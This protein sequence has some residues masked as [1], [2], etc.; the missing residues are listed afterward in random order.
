MMPS[1]TNQTDERGSAPAVPQ[2]AK[3]AVTLAGSGKRKPEAR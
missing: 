2:R 1:F 3:A